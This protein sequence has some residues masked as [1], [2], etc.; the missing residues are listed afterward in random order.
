[1]IADGAW[2]HDSPWRGTTLPAIR[3]MNPMQKRRLYFFLGLY[4]LFTAA[5]LACLIN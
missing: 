5:M 4:G 1:M 2:W 3:L